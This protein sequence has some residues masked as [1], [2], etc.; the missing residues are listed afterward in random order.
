MGILVS[1]YKGNLT[2]SAVND[3][4]FLSPGLW[5]DCPKEELRDTGKGIYVF[6]DFCGVE[7]ATSA[8]V[9]ALP[10]G[11]YVTYQDSTVTIGSLAT[12]HMGV[13]QIA[14]NDADLDE[15]SIQL[16]DVAGNVEFSSSY[17]NKRLW[18]EARVRVVTAVTNNTTSIAIG[19]AQEG[20][21]A[22]NALVDNTNALAAKDFVGF[23]TLAADN[24]GLDA[25]HSDGT[26]VVV[27]ESASGLSGQTIT[28]NTW[29]KAGLRQERDGRIYWYINGQKVNPDSGV[30]ASATN[31]PDGE[32][33]SP[34]LATKTGSAAE[35]AVD[36]DWWCVAQ[37][38]WNN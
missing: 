28:A 3:Q 18:F 21:A 38:W 10:S 19:L 12:D 30:L 11:R 6:E 20:F 36:L 32:E 37:E 29:V 35:G 34:V 15:G 2:T 22:A 1:T 33:L 26:E 31:F 7:A 8:T 17:T 5:S 13:L 4:R 16:G 9:F 27:K 14:G 24:D 23:R 25:V